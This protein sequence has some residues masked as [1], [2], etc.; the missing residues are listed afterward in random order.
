M[1]AGTVTARVRFQGQPVSMATDNTNNFWGL[2][3][4]EVWQEVIASKV[5]TLIA[6]LSSQVISMDYYSNVVYVGC[7]DG[8]TYSITTA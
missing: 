7:A 4:G 1:S 8:Q 2:D 5:L 3:N 6:R